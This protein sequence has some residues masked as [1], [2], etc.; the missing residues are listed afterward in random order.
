MDMRCLT[1]LFITFKKVLGAEQCHHTDA[2]WMLVQSHFSALQEAIDVRRAD[3][4]YTCFVPCHTTIGCS[5]QN[6]ISQT[7]RK[8]VNQT[9]ILH[10][11]YKQ[12]C[13]GQPAQ[14]PK[15]ARTSTVSLPSGTC[16]III[17]YL[18]NFCH[19]IHSSTRN[20]Y[21]MV[22]NLNYSTH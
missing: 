21:P 1:S 10:R 3:S 9:A 11:Y 8:S 15:K 16:V 14:R 20:K 13:L 22:V 4:D 5:L 7:L 2:S 12:P 17:Y 18:G 6:K 19:P